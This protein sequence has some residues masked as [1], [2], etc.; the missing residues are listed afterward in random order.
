MAKSKFIPM[1]RDAASGMHGRQDDAEFLAHW[2]APAVFSHAT[3]GKHLVRQIQDYV[4]KR[5]VTSELQMVLHGSTLTLVEI[6]SVLNADDRPAA[7]S[8]LIAAKLDRLG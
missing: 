3:E 6:D 5:E 7:A 1:T 2:K 4:R 8:Q